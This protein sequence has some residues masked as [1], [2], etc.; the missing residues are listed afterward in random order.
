MHVPNGSASAAQGPPFAGTAWARYGMCSRRHQ[1]GHADAQEGRSTG[2]G[3]STAV[4]VT[5]LS[6]SALG[7]CSFQAAGDPSNTV[8][9]GI[10]LLQCSERC[11]PNRGQCSCYAREGN[12]PKQVGSAFQWSISLPGFKLHGP[13]SGPAS[14][15]T[16]LGFVR[17]RS[18]GLG[19]C[20]VCWSW[21]PC[22]GP[23]VV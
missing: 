22:R 9:H 3:Q 2:S 8:G 10:M 5:S 23:R 21:R 11:L 14:S 16:E 19:P 18:V 13:I 20:R 6:L 1:C 4:R 17:A 12:V 15:C 7:V